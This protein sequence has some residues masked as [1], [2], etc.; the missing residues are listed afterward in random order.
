MTTVPAPR[1]R[2][3]RP[4]GGRCPALLPPSAGTV[5]DHTT[6]TAKE[7]PM[8]VTPE[9]TTMRVPLDTAAT[10]GQDSNSA[11]LRPPAEW[12]PAPLLEGLTT[13]DRFTSDLDKA[14]THERYLAEPARDHEAQEADLADNAAARRAGKPS[15]NPNAHRDQLAATRRAAREEIATLRQVLTTISGELASVRNQ[16]A[17]DGVWR[18]HVADTRAATVAA[19]DALIGQVDALVA[20]EAVDAWLSGAPKY[21]PAS[22]VFVTDLAPQILSRG[23]PRDIAGACDLSAVLAQLRDVV[24]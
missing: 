20:V 23:V 11:H 13:F 16:E 22:A 3:S 10:G 12:L 5:P 1:D 24:L 19:I 4:Q 21:A 18:T 7:N 6:T 15:K 14:M 8:T 17:T 9:R 2:T